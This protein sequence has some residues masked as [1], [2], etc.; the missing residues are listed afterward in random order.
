ME[1]A[2]VR[3]ASRSS[4][5][6]PK[7]HDG[8]QALAGDGVPALGL[9]DRNAFVSYAVA[10]SVSHLRSPI[11]FF[12]TTADTPCFTV[13]QPQPTIWIENGVSS[14]SAGSVNCS[15]WDRDS[16]DVVKD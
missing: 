5:T 13:I 9:M 14:V 12:P 7:P 8:T 15:A 6:N 10:M 3:F 16:R 4:M 11:S 2:A 1:N